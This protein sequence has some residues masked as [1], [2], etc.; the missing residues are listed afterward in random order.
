MQQGEDSPDVLE[1]YQAELSLLEVIAHQLARA[2]GA[3]V[4]YDDLV[5]AGREGLFDAARRFDPRRGV[6]FRAYASL[7]IK[8]AM[9]DGIRQQALPRRA[10]ER[11]AALT[12]S[13]EQSRGEVRSAFASARQGHT[14]GAAEAHLVSHLANM[15]T[16]AAI[17]P[18]ALIAAEAPAPEA[19]PD[20]EQQLE[21]AELLELVRRTIRE[22][23]PDEAGIIHAFYFEGRTL[24][25]IAQQHNLSRSWVSRLHAQAMRRLTKRL[26]Q[27][28]VQQ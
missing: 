17:G 14:E 24:N 5:S 8:G 15:A 23:A 3:S 26:K 27:G 9:I 1:R 25:D 6:P 16:A 12:A 19:G 4:N 20:P 22:M 13:L 7:R 18:M 10:Q 2:V 28:S 11:L 21:R